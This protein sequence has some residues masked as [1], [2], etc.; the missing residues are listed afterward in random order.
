[1]YLSNKYTFWYNNII[2]RG[3]NRVKE[4]YMEKHHIVPKSLGGTNTKDNLVYLTAKEHY[5]CH[6][7]LTKMTHG[8]ERS[9]MIKAFWM[10]STMGNKHQKRIKVGSRLYCKYKDLWLQQG[11][12]NKPKTEEHKSKLRGLKRSQKTKNK[13]SAARTGVSSGPRSQ[14]QKDAVGAI[15]RG[16]ARNEECSCI[17]CRKTTSITN[18]IRWHGDK[19]KKSPLFTER[20]IPK[21]QC[22]HC[23]KFIDYANYGQWHGP[24]CKL[25]HDSPIII[26]SN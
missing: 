26:L 19:C 6:L 12:H 1:M 24:K 16:V 15:W 9:K 21:K 7:L 4:G 8:D 5:I 2:H 22:E 13:I 10:I 20:I 23:S 11:G 17:Y 18:H 25:A 3:K 14:K